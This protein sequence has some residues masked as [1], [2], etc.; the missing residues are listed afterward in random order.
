MIIT[1][2][3]VPGAGKTTVGRLLAK[4]LGYEFL[5]IGEIRR[6][7]ARKKG[8]DVYKLNEIGEKEEWTDKEVDNY[9]AE[10]GK[11]RDNLIIESRLAYHF[12]P[13]SVKIFLDVNLKT[14]AKRI[15]ESQ[16]KDE[17]YK[18]VEEAVKR[19]KERMESDRKRYKKYY[20]I[21]FPEKTKFDLVIDTTNLTPEEVVK[22][23][24]DFISN[25]RD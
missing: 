4:T 11:T 18:S 9:T 19:L 25:K 5:S 21:D 20:G 14:G 22:K 13:H 6:E 2:S 7:I 16:R 17:K 1:I 8:M 3:G 12:I 24:L 10:L 23:I 15:F